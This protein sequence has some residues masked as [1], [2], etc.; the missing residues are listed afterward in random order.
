MKLHKVS[1]INVNPAAESAG[2]GRPIGDIVRD[3]VN[4]ISEIVRS[5]FRLVSLEVKQEAA[6]MKTG[7]IAIA[8]GNVL[9]LYG[10][11]FLLFGAVYLLATVWPTWLAA[12]AVGACVAI[13]GAVAVKVGI[14]KLKRSRSTRT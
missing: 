4:H 13:A 9:L 12:L 5:E 10:G 14:S 1:D 2:D 3:I 6:E 8:I 11:L 7:A